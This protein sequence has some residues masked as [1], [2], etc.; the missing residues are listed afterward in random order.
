[1]QS[2]K[3]VLRRFNPMEDKYVSREY[4]SYGVHLSEKLH[5]TSRKSLYIKMARDL[6]RAVLEEALRFAVDSGARRPGAL[7]MWKLK[8]IG[9]IGKKTTEKKALPSMQRAVTQA[10]EIATTLTVISLVIMVFG[11]VV[12]LRRNQPATTGSE[13]ARA[14][15]MCGGP[16]SKNAECQRFNR[17][18]SITVETQCDVRKGMCVP[19]NN[20]ANMAAFNEAQRADRTYCQEY[21]PPRGVLKPTGSPCNSESEC[22]S[23]LQCRLVGSYGRICAG[24]VETGSS[25]TTGATGATGPGGSGGGGTGGSTGGGLPTPTDPVVYEG[26]TDADHPVRGNRF[27][28]RGGIQTCELSW[29]FEEDPLIEELYLEDV[30]GRKFDFT[31]ESFISG[32]GKINEQT[33]AFKSGGVAVNFE[34]DYDH[35]KNRIQGDDML[36]V[37]NLGGGIRKE[38]VFRRPV[39][40]GTA[41][42]TLY[43]KYSGL[44]AGIRRYWYQRDAI[45]KCYTETITATPT[46]Q[47]CPANTIR[48][49]GSVQLNGTLPQV[50]NSHIPQ[51][52]SLLVRACPVENGS[53]RCGSNIQTDLDNQFVSP[54]ANGSADYTFEIDG[55]KVIDKEIGI[56]IDQNLW[57]TGLGQTFII[58]DSSGRPMTIDRYSENVQAN[59]CT[60]SAGITKN[61]ERNTI[62]R[63]TMTST[64]ISN[65]QCSTAQ[66]FRVTFAEAPTLTPTPTDSP[67]ECNDPCSKANDQCD[68]RQDLF[69]YIDM[70]RK[71]DNPTDPNCIPHTSPT[72]TSTPPP[73]IGC[74]LPCRLDN[75]YCD[76]SRN[77]KCYRVGPFGEDR[78]RLNHPTYWERTDC[79]TPTQTPPA[80]PTP[81][82]CEANIHFLIDNSGTV[83]QEIQNSMSKMRDAIVAY[84]RE[85]PNDRL[86]FSTRYFWRDLDTN[87]GHG[88]FPKNANDPFIFPPPP[89][90]FIW[91]NIKEALEKGRAGDETFFISD[92]LPSIVEYSN[93]RESAKC[94]FSSGPNMRAGRENEISDGCDPVETSG[95]RR[96]TCDASRRAVC[97]DKTYKTAKEDS[98]KIGKVVHSIFTEAGLY[99]DKQFMQ[100]VS[101]S[102]VLS[103]KDDANK[104]AIRFK[105]V[106]DKVC[107]RS[108][109]KTPPQ[110]PIPNNVPFAFTL[111]NSSSRT[112]S[113]VLLELCDDISG[114]CATKEVAVNAG[115]GEQL[116]QAQ[117][118]ALPQP[119]LT[120]TQG[121]TLSCTL[122]YTDGTTGA[123]ANRP[124]TLGDGARFDIEALQERV[125]SGVRTY[126]E[127]ADCNR[128]GAVNTIDY[129][130]LS[131]QI[132]DPFGATSVYS[133]D[134]IPTGS[135]VN[136]ADLS[137]ILSLLQDL[138]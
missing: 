117:S 81:V 84:R 118:I 65:N 22:Q 75:D 5:D 95:G 57:A 56:F 49:T 1:M 136:S 35:D 90:D 8:E 114:K 94:L 119:A 18:G 96:D 105:E 112:V 60:T 70:C 82:P 13:A 6:P 122:R 92:G 19:V 31:R 34:P 28:N 59:S 124:L 79:L 10:G 85:Y 102:D 100:D 126:S 107:N 127:L 47:S 46:P 69:C 97:S 77:Y 9:A 21:T 32:P 61:I 132:S 63:I 110:Q 53:I 99:N 108:N 66:N 123:C 91:T 45:K 73:V 42:M 83:R 64:A 3:S 30:Q 130:I 50:P 2:I 88:E 58:T 11:G 41:D 44:R 38:W 33:V 62:C 67:L 40:V 120:R 131:A 98:K 87:V 48:F 14:L 39:W 72:P 52:A 116:A 36:I 15:S 17:L 137:V 113:S 25:G 135:G 115:P 24:P 103:T 37:I 129:S 111:S 20:E 128:D 134:I 71:R 68:R 23:G 78:C 54:N 55:S 104:F 93:G 125:S 76:R 4:Q 16:C 27:I 133:C 89:N 138:Q 74:N 29:S 101:K 26:S 121:Y 86:T 80:T 43:I 106:F 109:N 7:F 12:G 51:R